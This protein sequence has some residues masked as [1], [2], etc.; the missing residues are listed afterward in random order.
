RR[1]LDALPALLRG[2]PRQEARLAQL[3]LLA[4]EKTAETERLAEIRRT[5]GIVE[6]GAFL[7]GLPAGHSGRLV[8]LAEEMLAEEEAGHQRNLRVQTLLE[9]NV[10]V[11][12]FVGGLLVAVVMGGTTVL[13]IRAARARQRA[14]KNLQ[15][16]NELQRAVLDGGVFSVIA[17]EPNGVIRVFNRGAERMLGYTREEM[18]GRQTPELI[19]V[20]AEVAARAVDLSAQLGRRIEPGFEAFVARA[21]LGEAD[22]REW[23]YVRKDGSRLPVQVSVTALRDEA[24]TITGFLGI[25]RDLTDQKKAEVMLQASEEKLG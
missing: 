18:V 7:A 5:K 24:G 2:Q 1:Q 16:V 22:E 15:E 23:T 9:A 4:A 10:R 6:A 17:T 19:H 12:L 11:V 21:R 25:A 8:S 13:S 14:E 3:R 20:G